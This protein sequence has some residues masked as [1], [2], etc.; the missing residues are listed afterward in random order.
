[1]KKEDMVPG[2]LVRIPDTEGQPGAR[3]V[4]M[5]GGPSLAAV[6]LGYGR[7]RFE[8]QGLCGEGIVIERSYADKCAV[9][10]VQKPLDWR[11]EVLKAEAIELAVKYISFR[12]ED[13]DWECYT[14]GN[15]GKVGITVKSSIEDHSVI[16]RDAPSEVHAHLADLQAE[17]QSIIKRLSCVR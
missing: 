16:L 12:M 7:Y 5:H 13:L 4:M 15:T 11:L 1:M 8:K 6:V 2:T 10:L 17:M 9:L 3:Q 14:N